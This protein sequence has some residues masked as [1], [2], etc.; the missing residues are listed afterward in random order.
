MMSTGIHTLKPLRHI[1]RILVMSWF[2]FSCIY[3][4]YFV[5]DIQSNEASIEFKSPNVIQ[6]QMTNTMQCNLSHFKYTTLLLQQL[7]TLPINRSKYTTKQIDHLLHDKHRL[8]AQ[9][10]HEF[11]SI[12]RLKSY[13]NTLYL[14]NYHLLHTS[15]KEISRYGVQYIRYFM[16]LLNKYDTLPIFDIVI[17]QSSGHVFKFNWNDTKY[18]YPVCFIAKGLQFRD[19]PLLFHMVARGQLILQLHDDNKQLPTLKPWKD[20]KDIA[21]FRG[22]TYKMRD[23]MVHYVNN[24]I[25]MEERKLFD[26]KLFKTKQV[27]LFC[28]RWNEHNCFVLRN[29]SMTYEQEAQYK[30]II[31]V[32]GLDTRDAFVRQM[33]YGSVILKYDTKRTEFWYH[34]L[35]DGYHYFLWQNVTDLVHLMKRVVAEYDDNELYQIGQNAKQYAM[36]HFDDHS[37]ACFVMNMIDIYN[38]YFYDISSIIANGSYDVKLPSVKRKV[39]LTEYALNY[40]TNDKL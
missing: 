39:D 10:N 37:L 25:S 5:Y 15:E 34:D 31:V 16:H 32:D 12:T 11:A 6:S 4:Y 2:I 7:Q 23:N 26:A 18:Q 22:S 17:Y 28:G 35:I 40:A 13:N 8:C 21:V 27:Q 24:V 30:F 38:Q 9:Y 20:R 14:D 33:F 3:F 36:T 19:I 29:E 1:F